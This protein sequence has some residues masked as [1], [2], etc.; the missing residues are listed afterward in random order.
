MTSQERDLV[1]R[2]LNLLHRLMPPEEPY[3][4][5]PVRPDCPVALFARRFLLREPASDLTSAELRTFFAE[6]SASGEVE[7]LSKAEFLSR[8]PAVMESVFGARKCHN[9]QRNG[10]RVRGFR[11][12]GIRLDTCAP[13]TMELEPE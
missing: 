9:I 1:R 2:A 13:A 4:G 8:L 3:A 10:R 11:G 6:V 12:V 5:Y 7:P